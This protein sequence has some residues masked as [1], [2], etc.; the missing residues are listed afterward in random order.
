MVLGNDTKNLIGPQVHENIV[1][2]KRSNPQRSNVNRIVI[3]RYNV[4][5]RLIIIIFDAKELK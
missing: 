1:V 4:N 3:Y 2:I 5:L